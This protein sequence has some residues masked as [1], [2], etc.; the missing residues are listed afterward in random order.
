LGLTGRSGGS[1]LAVCLLT[2]LFRSLFCLAAFPGER[3]CGVL[4]TLPGR[5]ALGGHLGSLP[6][7]GLRPL[8]G[9]FKLSGDVVDV[10]L[11]ISDILLCGF[12]TGLRCTLAVFGGIDDFPGRRRRGCGLGCL[13]RGGGRRC[14]GAS[15][16]GLGFC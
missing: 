1:D 2:D 12:S 7:G 6:L 11:E 10:R 4:G 14:L 8:Y 13:G 5:V 3:G 16:G 15:A 9:S